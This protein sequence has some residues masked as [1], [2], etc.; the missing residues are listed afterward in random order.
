MDASQGRVEAARDGALAEP[1]KPHDDLCFEELAQR[2]NYQLTSDN[3]RVFA[4]VVIK[5][6]QQAKSPVRAL[7]VGCGRG[8]GSLGS[9]VSSL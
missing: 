4:R 7:D 8:I 6:C 5:Q 3:R 2:Y 1:Q 9:L